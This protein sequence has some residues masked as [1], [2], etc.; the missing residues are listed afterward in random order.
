MSSSLPSPEGAWFDDFGCTIDGSVDEL[1]YSMKG[2]DKIPEAA[3]VKIFGGELH[4]WPN[5]PNRFRA[6]DNA[7]LRW[8]R[9]RKFITLVIEV[10]NGKVALI[11]SMIEPEGVVVRTETVI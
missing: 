5:E 4:E 7:L 2:D 1:Y 6:L 11:K 10:P 8:L 9:E 3:E